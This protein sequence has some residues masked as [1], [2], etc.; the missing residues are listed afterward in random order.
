MKNYRYLKSIFSLALFSVL[1]TACEED[2]ETSL[3]NFVGFEIDSE[4]LRSPVSIPENETVSFDIAVWASETSSSDRT[5]ELT[6]TEEMHLQFLA[7]E[8]LAI[9][10]YPYYSGGYSFSNVVIPAGSLEGSFTVTLTDND[11]LSFE[12][13]YLTFGFVGESGRH[14][15]SPVSI[16]V[17]QECLDTIVEFNLT[18]DTWPDETTWEIYDLTGTPTVIASGGPYVNPDDDF[19]EL[20]FPFCLATG[21]YGVVVY[22]A[23]G[24]GGPQFSVTSAT[25]GSLVPVTTVGGTQS[26]ATFTIN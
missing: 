6:S 3:S 24:D 26:S 10:Q 13:Q 14:F 21:T 23:Y 18:L 9:S 4:P 5:Y 11:A 12:N 15:Q 17:A 7:S 16:P 22:D 2:L 20:V 19:A 1:F 8:S 25:A